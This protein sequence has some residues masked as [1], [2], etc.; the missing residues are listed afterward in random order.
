M[1][2]V[3]D[4][5]L[6]LALPA[7]GKSEVRK[8]LAWLPPGKCRD[9][10]GVGP[11]VQ[12]DDFPYVHFMRR[13]DE[14]LEKLGKSRLFYHGPERGFREGRDWGS[15]IELV[16]QDREALD[17]RPQ[18]PAKGAAARHLLARLDEAGMKAGIKPRLAALDGNSRARLADALEREAA[19]LL[20]DLG[21]ARTDSLAGKTIVIEFARGGPEGSA[22]PLPAPFGYRYSLSML[23]PRILERASVLYIWVTPEESRRKNVARTDPNDPGSILHH[24][25]PE[26]VMRGDYGCDDIEWL[27]GRSDRPD[28]IRLEAHGRTWYLP[29][30]RFDNRVDR[31]SFIRADPK[32][33]AAADVQALH[34]GL[35]EAFD[36]LRR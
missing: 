11:N 29:L 12:L 4:T 9:D 7:S 18:T 32:K 6:L 21:D 30:G 1:K 20:R 36:A 27:L 35:K 19:A 3:I 24:G 28:T 5:L 14:E 22:M 34:A 13:V 16:N 33:W 31:T 25:V 15:L 26:S 23:S 2:D 10:F 17:T 8:Y